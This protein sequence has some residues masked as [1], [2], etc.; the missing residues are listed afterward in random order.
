V[1]NREFETSCL[2]EAS[3]LRAHNF[4]FTGRKV[5]GRLGNRD[6]IAWV[7]A[8]PE[9][10]AQEVV[11]SLSGSITARTLQERTF[12]IRGHIPRNPQTRTRT[13]NRPSQS[14]TEG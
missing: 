9:G 7:F 10:R 5:I 2:D 1:D 14:P 4:K 12:L 6:R 11:D 3:W 13:R 8:D